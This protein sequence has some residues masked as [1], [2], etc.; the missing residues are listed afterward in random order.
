MCVQQYIIH[1]LCVLVPLVIRG[2]DADSRSKSV[3]E[4][5]IEYMGNYYA[6]HGQFPWVVEIRTLSSQNR[7]EQELWSIGNLIGPRYVVTSCNAVANFEVVGTQR[8]RYIVRAKNPRNYKVMYSPDYPYHGPKWY[9]NRYAKWRSYKSELKTGTRSIA[10][11]SPHP[12]CDPQ[13]FRYF[14]GMVELESEPIRP[15]RLF[16]NY[17]PPELDAQNLFRKWYY[18]RHQSVHR[19][20]LMSTWGRKYSD[21]YTPYMVLDFKIKSKILYQEWSKCVNVFNK[22]A[23][24]KTN[25]QLVQEN[26]TFCMQI[27]DASNTMG[28][29][30]DHDRG[31]PIMWEGFFVGIVISAAKFEFCSLLEPLPFIALSIDDALPYWT[32]VERHILQYFIDNSSHVF[33][34]LTGLVVLPTGLSISPPRP[35]ASAIAWTIVGLLL[36]M[37]SAIS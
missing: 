9:V 8:D 13:H 31:A 16:V 20:A 29:I 23:W 27:H 1:V 7:S 15:F 17:A 28:S 5:M 25:T 14:F 34:G 24:N 21:K 3:V 4:S 18:L 30:C 2:N 32:N 35:T 12:L 33:P 6:G 19:P 26:N 11:M 22:L 10:R 37:L 36:L